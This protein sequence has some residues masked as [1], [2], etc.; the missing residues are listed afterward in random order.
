MTKSNR[1]RVAMVQPFLAHYREPIYNL[2]CR[3]AIPDPHYTF[4]SD[5]ESNIGLHTIDLAMAG[6]PPNEGGLNWHFLRNVWF[7][8]VFLWQ[9]GLLSIVVRRDIDVIIFAGIMYYW[10]TW[11]AALIAR[12]TGKR[13]LMWTHGYLREEHNLKGWLRERFYK[14][15]HGLILYGNT[16][17]TLLL[18]RGFGNDDLYVVYNSLDYELQRKIRSSITKDH[19]S[20]LRNRLF[21]NPDLPVAVFIGRLTPQKEIGLLIDATKILVQQGMRLNLLFV[22]DGP[23]KSRLAALCDTLGLVDYCVFYGACYQEQELGPLIS[24]ADVCVSPGEVGLTC[25]HAL[26]YGIPVITHNN[27]SRQMPEWE[28]IVPGKTGD[29]FRHGSADDLAN[30]IAAWCY[31]NKDSGKMKEYCQQVIDEFYNPFVQRNVINA[32]ISGVPA[33]KV[34]RY[35][36]D[37]FVDN[38]SDAG[39][40]QSQH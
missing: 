7:A 3:Q 26:V 1:L 40:G 4:Y 27:S 30:V 5:R 12:I 21:E 16:A 19:L 15:S 10:S 18:K 17:R 9:I 11:I 13:V 24:L 38:G 25:M 29:F 32:A 33:S 20:N 14:L 2:L 37:L 22:G 6:L 28:A 31:G 36:S 35:I 8:K 39:K 34:N 23:E